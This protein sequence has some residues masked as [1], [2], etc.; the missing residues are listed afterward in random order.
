VSALPGVGEKLAA[1]IVK[2]RQKTGGFKSTQE[3]MNVKDI[4]S[5]R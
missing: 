5:Y 4:D 3:L 1:R 2:H